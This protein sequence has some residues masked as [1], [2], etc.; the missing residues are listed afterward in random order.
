[1]T[2][3]SSMMSLSPQ[4]VQMRTPVGAALATMRK[5]NFHHLPVLDDNGLLMG[6]VTD[7]DVLKFV[8]EGDPMAWVS[9]AVSTGT[10]RATH[11]DTPLQVLARQLEEGRDCTLVVNAIGQPIGVFTER[12]AMALASDHL[13]RD[14]TVGEVMH[15]GSMHTVHP[16]RAADQALKQLMEAGV[17]HLLVVQDEE[18]IGVVSH[19]DLVGVEQ[20]PVSTLI[21]NTLRYGRTDT[22]LVDA[23]DAMQEEKFGCLPILGPEGEPVGVLTRTDVLRA[24]VGQMEDEYQAAQTPPGVERME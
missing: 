7:Y 8:R 19:R 11:E 14:T 22:R 1:M 20:A 21:R 4:T 10:S 18:V 2:Q 13:N 5:N 3:I 17:R 23:V 15:E 6:V 12:D 16:D 24:L 9:Q